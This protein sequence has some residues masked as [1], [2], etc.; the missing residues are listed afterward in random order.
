LQSTYT[1]NVTAKV[2]VACSVGRLWDP[3]QFFRMRVHAQYGAEVKTTV[4]GKRTHEKH[5]HLPHEAYGL[6]YT[7]NL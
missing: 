4:T 6:Y 2:F 5:D 7:S 3:L 1:F